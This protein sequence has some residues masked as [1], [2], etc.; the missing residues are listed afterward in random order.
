MKNSL[1]YTLAAGL[2]GLVGCFSIETA[3]VASSGTAVYA[4]N[5]G[6]YLFNCVPLFC[7]NAS[8]DPKCS[9]VMF[10][11]D[12]MMDKIQARVIADAEKKGLRFEDAS[13][14]CTDQI[15]LRV[16]VLAMEIPVPYILTYREKQLS[17]VYK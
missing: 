2:L 15:T 1:K 7:G 8:E 6:M 5:Y 9:F 14:H 10:R 17:G 12:V 4:R 13:W 16:P 11:N 3:P